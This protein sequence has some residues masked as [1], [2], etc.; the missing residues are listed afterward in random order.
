M[1]DNESTAQVAGKR[2]G[3]RAVA[4]ILAILLGLP[5][6][7]ALALCAVALVWR[8]DPSAYMPENFTAYA[9]LPSA[10][11]FVEEALHLKALDAALS[12]GEA[13]ALRGT[14]RSLRANAFLRSP[15]FRRLADIRVDAAAYPGGFVLV[16]DLGLRS[17]LT[18]LAP[19]ILAIAPSL[20]DRVPGL[21]W[22]PDAFP[23]RFRYQ[24]E[25]LT[26]YALFHRNALVAASSPELLEAAARPKRPQGDRALAEVLGDPGDASLRFLADTGS[27]AGGLS[28]GSGPLAALVSRLGFPSLSVIDL[29][30]TD[31]RVSLS[32]ELPYTTD[33]EALRAVLGR[34][35]GTPSALTRFPESAAWFSL[36]SAAKP[37]ELWTLASGLLGPDS[38]SAFDTADAASTAAFGMGL[39]ELLFSWMGDELGVLG[40][41]LGPAP[42]FFASI[43][44]EKARKRVFEQAFDSLLMGRDISSMVG[45]QRVPRIVFPRWM[46]AFLESVGVKLVEPFY[47]IEDGFIWLS[48]SAETLAACV[49]ES[50]EGRLLVKSERWKSAAEGI[51]PEASAM[52]YYNL[53]R[54]VPFFLRGST[55]LAQALKLYRRGIATFR[56]DRGALTLDLSAVA[57]TGPAAS[58]LPGYPLA[59]GGRMDSDPITGR[60]DDGSPMAYW[61]A[62]RK[63][64]ALELASGARTELELDDQA[65]IA[66][67]LRRGRIAAVWAVS[68]R[69]TVYRMD[70][71][72]V[73]LP[74][75]P[76]VTGVP[77]S[78]PPAA[79]L[80]ALEGR[81]LVPVSQ[82]PALMAVDPDGNLSHGAVMHARSRTAPAVAAWG[83]AALPRS[84]DSAL[85]LFGPELSILPGWPVTLSG[86]ASA[87]PAMAGEG[88]SARVAAV[89][90]AGEFCVWTQSGAVDDGFPVTL[91]GTFDAPPA[92][93]PGL[94]SWYLVSVEGTLWRVG[95]DGSLLGSAPLSRGGSRDSALLVRDE[96]GDGREEIYLA[97]GGD[98]LYAFAGDLSPLQGYPVAGSG[99]PSFIDA[100]G[101][102]DRDMVTRGADDTVHA[103]QG[104]TP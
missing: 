49:A 75:F 9:S 104:G 90:E 5:L 38:A 19:A 42:V 103:H 17:A 14:V 68:A 3:R 23:P 102:G 10:S 11:A 15:L 72:L 61:T 33:D 12:S 26:V 4:W 100:D 55:G 47:L 25:G 52:V 60:A 97:G 1:E 8:A 84:F 93:A 43:A 77:V 85:Y 20:A 45:D 82:E 73:P 2:R 80:G 6:L 48:S 50:R 101:D 92:W 99:L 22:E 24:T 51:S 37:D 69:G 83:V 71:G 81:L 7:A 98:A 62:G 88:G 76:V 27:L 65:F 13:G 32:V 87:P 40:S 59:S 86:L 96:D 67:D 56:T 57:V 21:E 78:G 95:P 41:D 74:G 94:R 66:L 28:S 16:A 30:L 36:L 46:R 79:G 63:V 54:S 70:A 58:E 18:R 35:S 44:D 31:S 53:D 91:Y 39:S 34:R 29:S 64:V 89:T